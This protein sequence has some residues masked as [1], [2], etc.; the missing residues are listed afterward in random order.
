MVIAFIFTPVHVTAY[1]E[2]VVA[3]RCFDVSLHWSLSPL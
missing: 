2:E 3:D 1:G